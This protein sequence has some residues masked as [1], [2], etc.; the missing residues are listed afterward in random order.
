MVRPSGII[1]RLFLKARGGSGPDLSRGPLSDRIRKTA[2]SLLSDGHDSSC[3]EVGVGEGL[4]A[5]S[6]VSWG[7][8]A[9]M[10]GLDMSRA[11]LR[12]AQKRIGGTR[13]FL[14]VCARGDLPPFKGGV[15]SRV[16][17]INTLHNQP[18]WEEAAA[19]IRAMCA[20]ADRGGSILFDIRNGRDPLICWAYRFSTVIDPSTKRLPVRAYS[21]RRVE[22]LLKS[23]GF[24]VNRKV[25]VC[26]P[27]WPIP[28]AYVIEAVR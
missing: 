2:L 13:S 25:A 15:F 10:I 11:N 20:L 14:A 1:A 22:E 23:S 24:R 6:V 16:I 21:F 3:L 5:E 9:Q 7:K 28:S 18:S 26:Y 17:C 19:V 27:F 12:A 8:T 4:L